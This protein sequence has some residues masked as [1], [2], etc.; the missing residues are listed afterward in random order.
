[1]DFGEQIFMYLKD[2]NVAYILLIVGLWMAVIAATTP[3]TGF[4]EAAAAIAIVLAAIGLFNVTVNIAGVLLIIVGFVLFLVDVFAATHG[5]LLIA[6][7]VALLFGSLILFP[8][9]EGVQGLSGWLIGGSTLVSAGLGSIVLHALYRTRQS[10][11]VK[12]A[13][14]QVDGARGRVR[15]SIVVGETGTVRVAGQAWS[16]VADEPLERGTEVIVKRREGLTLH[17][18]RAAKTSVE[19][20]ATQ[21]KSS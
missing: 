14:L 21:Q 6:G 4:A 16:A 12:L 15:K 10:G 8:S 18:A 2:P 1:M 19:T 7:A 9:E 13:T 17:V 11:G 20:G 5:V 3:G